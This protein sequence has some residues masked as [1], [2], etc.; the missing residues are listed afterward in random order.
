MRKS[1]CIS[2]PRGRLTWG[3]GAEEADF[4]RVRDDPRC[5]LVLVGV[6]PLMPMN[7]RSLIDADQGDP[8]CNTARP[9][10][11]PTPAD[12]IDLIMGARQC[13]TARRTAP[14]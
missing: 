8:S 12:R 4:A 14:D 11:L 13:D 7:A 2:R 6:A 3:S 1:T 10:A 5:C 9:N